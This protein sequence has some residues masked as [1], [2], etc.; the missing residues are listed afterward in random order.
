MAVVAGDDGAGA[1]SA[2]PPPT[3]PRAAVAFAALGRRRTPATAMTRAK[4]ST[5][6]NEAMTTSETT[7]EDWRAGAAGGEGDWLVRRQR[8]GPRAGGKAL[9]GGGGAV[10]A[11]PEVGLR[12]AAGCLS[13]DSRSREP[14]TTRRSLTQC[15]K[16]HSKSLHLQRALSHKA[17]GARVRGANIRRP[18]PRQSSLL[19]SGRP[20]RG[21]YCACRP[22]RSE[23]RREP[24]PPSFPYVSFPARVPPKP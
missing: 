22:R 24:L 2:T 15:N 13:G 6:P 1:H 23:C 18:S 14:H 9:G 11:R 10:W 4:R 7:S 21:W 16:R 17:Q 5:P 20:D 12:I 8:E 19:Q 3:I